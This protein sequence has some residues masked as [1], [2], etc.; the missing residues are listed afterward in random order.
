MITCKGL[1]T[2][3]SDMKI[4]WCFAAGFVMFLLPL[5]WA[6]VIAWAYGADG[7]GDL[8]GTALTVATVP[9]ALLGLSTFIV[10]REPMDGK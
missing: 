9:A 10:A 3:E 5:V 1:L 7:R 6:V 8:L 4:V 2:E